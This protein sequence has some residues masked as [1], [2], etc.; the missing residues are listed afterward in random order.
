MSKARFI[1]SLFGY[2]VLGYILYL[3]ASHLY[4]PSRTFNMPTLLWLTHLFL[5]Y[6]HEAGHFFF[7]V[8][9]ET[10]YVMGGSIFQIIIPIA[11]F[12]VAKREG[13]PL[14]NVALFFT[15]ISIIDVSLYMKDAKERLL[16]LIGGLSKAHHDWGRLFL[17]WDSIDLA[18]PIGE[19]LFWAGFILSTAG[20][21]FGVKNTIIEYR[22]T[23][24]N[25]K[26]ET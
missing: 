4:T 16:P 8:F 6:I 7:R 13:S 10:L 23:A 25:D 17:Q 5:L 19:I 3:A 9:G 11:W 21:F 24:N 2:T 14:S 22:V 15:G 1:I 18:Y 20:L 26:G 12:I